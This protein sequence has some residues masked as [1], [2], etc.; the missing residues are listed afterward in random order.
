MMCAPEQMSVFQR[1]ARGGPNLFG[2]LRDIS[3]NNVIPVIPACPE[4]FPLQ[5]Q[6]SGQAGMTLYAHF[7]LAY[8]A[9][10]G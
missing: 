2:R 1:P 10:N 5:R 4:S 8:P 7:Q 9:S 3:C 6:D